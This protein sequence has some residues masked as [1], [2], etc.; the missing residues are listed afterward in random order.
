MP[1]AVSRLDDAAMLIWFPDYLRLP[2]D[3]LFLAQEIIV[4]RDGAER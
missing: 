4:K 1:A 3:T 2:R